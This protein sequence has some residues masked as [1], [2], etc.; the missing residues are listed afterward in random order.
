MKHI[1][2]LLTL[3]P[4]LA[5]AQ[6]QTNMVNNTNLTAYVN[7]VI[8]SNTPAVVQHLMQAGNGRYPTIKRSAET[9]VDGYACSWEMESEISVRGI[10]CCWVFYAR[11][12]GKT[13]RL[14]D[15]HGPDYRE[16]VDEWWTELEI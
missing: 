11:K 10:G 5:S 12:D 16:G 9:M 2:L 8:S 4:L 6:V 3:F 14:R 13:F 15:G 7:G 1:I